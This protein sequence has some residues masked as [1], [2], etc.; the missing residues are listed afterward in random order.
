M[1]NYFIN[2]HKDILEVILAGST[3]TGI[4]LANIQTGL[5]IMVAIASLGFIIYKWHC[6]YI[7]RKNKK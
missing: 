4:F 2:K 6:V 7:D 5:Q 1:I 3:G